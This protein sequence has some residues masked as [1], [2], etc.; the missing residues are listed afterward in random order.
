MVKYSI[1]RLPWWLS[2]RESA[3][4]QETR[5]QS[6]DWE[7]PLGRKQLPTPVP[8]PGKSHG[9]GSLEGYSAWGLKRAGH[10]LVSKQQQQQVFHCADVARAA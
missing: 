7:D 1:V 9:Q 10:D 6:L 4:M 3:C 2:G 5:V 8:L